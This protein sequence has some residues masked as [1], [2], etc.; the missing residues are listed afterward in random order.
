MIPLEK[1]VSLKLAKRLKELRVRPESVFWWSE[2]ASSATLW[3]EEAADQ[4][5]IWDDRQYAV[6]TVAALGA[7][8]PA[9]RKALK[10]VHGHCHIWKAGRASMVVASAHE[11]DCRA[12]RLL[13][14]VE[15]GS[16][17]PRPEGV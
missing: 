4:H 6:C 13:S 17:R 3:S 7:L 9:K 15:H 8:L 1:V 5:T 2:H 10:K 16:C 12:K 14:V 11:A